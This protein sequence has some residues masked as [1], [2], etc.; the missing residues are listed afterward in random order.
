MF[1]LSDPFL[2]QNR[3]CLGSVSLQGGSEAQ[4]VP[5]EEVPA[6]PGGVA[7]GPGAGPAAVHRRLRRGPA[8]VAARRPAMPPTGRVKGQGYARHGEGRTPSGFW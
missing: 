3:F 4:F 1:D 6:G 5:Q 7:R 2:N 8:A